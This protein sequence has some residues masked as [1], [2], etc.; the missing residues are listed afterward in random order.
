MRVSLVFA[1][2]LVACGAAQAQGTLTPAPDQTGVTVNFDALPIPTPRWKPSPDEIRPLAQARPRWKPSADAS[3]S[4]ALAETPAAADV[5][6]PQVKPA[7]VAAAPSA[8]LRTSSPL[9]PPPPT[10]VPAPSLTPAESQTLALKPRPQV[11]VTIVAPPPPNTFPVEISGQAAV[12]PN[13]RNIDPTDG[14]AILSRVRFTNGTA[15]IPAQA[16]PTLDSLA[17]RLLT[18]SERVRLAAFSGK[19]GDFS[20]T[21]R[22][23]SL[24]RALAVRAYLVGK[25]VPVERV[26][27]LA[28]GG[29]TDGI[30]D[31][32]D[33]LARGT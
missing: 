1:S 32:V 8:A 15:S 2:V 20:S 24:Q 9:S 28:F 22:R 17:E 14:F 33:V 10:A 31:R 3:E 7:E 11:P 4:T 29:A 21:A 5:A 16:V 27:V 26:D 25:G 23:L 30:S 12:D 6:T 13:A 18:S 19:A